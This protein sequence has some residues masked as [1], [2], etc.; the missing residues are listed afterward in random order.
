M[1]STSS[2]INATLFGTAR[3]THQIA[4]E[5]AIP[6]VLSFRNREGIPVYALLLI[7]GAT[8]AFTAVGTLTQIVEFG[9]V[10]FLG[11]FAVTNAVNLRLADETGSNR[12]FPAL[13]LVGTLVAIPTVLYHLYRTDVEILLWIVG[14]FLALFV[15]EFLYL[16]RSPFEPSGEEGT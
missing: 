4:T 1:K 16:E 13:G 9:S 10:A 8:C 3:L 2:G 12:V 5:G 7:G 11:T 6:E 15:L 14:I